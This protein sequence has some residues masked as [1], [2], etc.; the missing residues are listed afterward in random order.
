MK[1]SQVYKRR[2]ASQSLG[3]VAT[4]IPLPIQCIVHQNCVKELAFFF[5][6]EIFG[7]KGMVACYYRAHRVN[8]VRKLWGDSNMFF[9]VHLL[10]LFALWNSPPLIRALF[11]DTHWN[12]TPCNSLLLYNLCFYWGRSVTLQTSEYLSCSGLRTIF[13]LAD[14]HIWIILCMLCSWF[15][16]FYDFLLQLHSNILHQH[17]LKSKQ[18][19]NCILG[20]CLYLI[21]INTWF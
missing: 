2:Y 11:I 6:W 18:R 12:P 17:F 8:G 1:G 10:C 14:A 4:F 15:E 5:I 13:A 3:C 19:K 9:C 20:V 21:L 16:R 7:R